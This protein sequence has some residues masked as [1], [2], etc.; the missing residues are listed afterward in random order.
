[1]PAVRLPLARRPW[2][3][4]PQFLTK[5]RHSRW[6]IWDKV[7]EMT[8]REC[9]LGAEPQRSEQGVAPPLRGHTAVGATAGIL[10]QSLSSGPVWGLG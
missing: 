2:A 1:M 6:A 5:R 3:A 9:G 8:R 7:S 10:A 4:L